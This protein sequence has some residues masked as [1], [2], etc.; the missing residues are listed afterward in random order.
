MVGWWLLIPL[1]NKM[2]HDSCG[3]WNAVG[4]ADALD[5]GAGRA[6]AEGGG[7]D[8]VPG[9]RNRIHRSDGG[10]RGET[11]GRARVKRSRES[12]G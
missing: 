8:G 5:I 9:D 12:S 2:L 4:M 1:I 3:S 6:P 10:R 7:N 11:A